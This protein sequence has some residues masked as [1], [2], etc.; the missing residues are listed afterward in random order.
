MWNIWS[1]NDKKLPADSPEWW[2]TYYH[3]TKAIDLKSPFRETEFAVIDLE[4][5]GLDILQDRIISFGLIPVINFEIWAGNSFQCFVKQSYFD[6][7]SVPIHGL[8]PSDIKDGLSEKQFLKSIIPRLAG[9]VIVGHHIGYDIAMINQSLKRNYN[10]QLINP[11][12][13]TGHLYKKAYR[14]KFL[15]NKYQAP[16]PSLDEIAGEFKIETQDRHSAMGDALVTAFIF[17]K[18]IR[19]MELSQP[20]DLKGLL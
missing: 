6:K 13:D 5:T 8:L 1:N 17:M 20:I 16:I 19:E 14:S 15:Y 4:A 3:Q 12:L 9:Q 10:V 2:K 11:S 7:E 18:L